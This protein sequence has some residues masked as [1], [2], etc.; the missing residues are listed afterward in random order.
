MSGLATRRQATARASLEADLDRVETSRLSELR[1][2]WKEKLGYDP[3]PLRSR[4]IFRRMLGYRLQA[5]ALGDLSPSVKRKLAAIEAR[6][7]SPGEKSKPAAVRLRAG[8]LLIREWKGVRHEVRVTADGF[9]HEGATYK[10][11][12]E[13]ARVITGSRWNGPLFFGLRDKPAGVA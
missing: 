6:R 9:G 13:V 12:S 10:S 4:E 3:P 7:S 8:T 1:E 11:L 2:I 5:A